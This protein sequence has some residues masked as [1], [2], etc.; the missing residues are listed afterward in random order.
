MWIILALTTFGVALLLTRRFLDPSSALFVLDYPSERSLHRRPIP[1]SGGIAIACA[2]FIGWSLVA[3]LYEYP[4]SLLWL[5]LGAGVLVFVSFLDDRW[6][7][8]PGYRLVA[9]VLVAM[10]LSVNGFVLDAFKL[11]TMSWA[12]TQ[13]LA[14]SLSCIYVVW[15]I[16]LYNFMDGM[17]GFAAGM[18]LIGFGT[19]AVMGWSSGDKTFALLSLIAASA[20]GGFLVLNFPPAHIFMGD[21]GSALL[22]LLVAALSLWADKE[23]IFPLWISVLVFSPFVVDATVTIVRRLLHVQRL[24][25]AHKTHF[26]QRLVQLGWGHRR[27][28]L[29]EYVLMCACGVSAVLA[30]R[31]SSRLQ[32]FLLGLWTLVYIFLIRF[33]YRLERRQQ[34]QGLPD[35]TR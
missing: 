20:A 17:D 8:S 12:L 3:A 24:W 1:R 30:N 2:L 10:L 19:F 29:W 21:V 27:T 31:L 13:G 5:G 22:G 34:R 28:V 14:F 25:E 9:H 32:W 6:S 16:N 15:V 4:E 11:P 18:S 33:V 7:V 35:A 26:Y 23:N